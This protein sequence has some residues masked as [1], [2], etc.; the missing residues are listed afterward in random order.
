MRYIVLFENFWVDQGRNNSFG[1]RLRCLE[2]Y[3]QEPVKSYQQSLLLF[4]LRVEE[5]QEDPNK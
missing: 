3:T 5:S 2:L 4:D 1:K